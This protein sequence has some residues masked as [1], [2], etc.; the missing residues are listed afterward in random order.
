MRKSIKRILELSEIVLP[1]KAKFPQAGEISINSSF[2]KWQKDEEIE[3]TFPEYEAL[4]N[5]LYGKWI[6]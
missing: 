3:L 2:K 5:S 6:N 1:Y 4:K